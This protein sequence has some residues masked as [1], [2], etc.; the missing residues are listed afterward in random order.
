MRNVAKRSTAFRGLALAALLLSAA[1]AVAQEEDGSR[2]VI[3]LKSRTFT[4]SPGVEPALREGLEKAGRGTVGIVQL[5]EVPDEAVRAQLERAGVVLLDYIPNNA[6]IARIPVDL[7]RATAVPGVRFIGRLL[8]EDKLAPG[9]LRT[10]ADKAGKPELTLDVEAFEGTLE[11]AVGR[12]EALGGRVTERDAELSVLRIALPRGAVRDLAASDAV[13][14]VSPELP[15]TLH[16]NHSRNNSRA[17][18]VQAAPYG[19]T[20]AGVQLG[21]WD[22][23]QISA[24]PDFGTRLTVVEPGAIDNHATHVAGTMAGAGTASASAGFPALHFRGY[25]TGADILGFDFAGVPY[26]EHNVGINTW[27]IDNSQNSWGAN[28]STVLGNCALYGDYHGFSREY[29][30]IVTGIYGRRIPVV[31]SAGNERQDG[32]CGM[33]AVSPFLNYGIVPPPAT[34]KDVIAVGAINGDNGA[35]TT[36]SSWGPTDDGRLR[37]DLA[38]AGCNAGS[39]PAPAIVSTWPTGYAGICGTSMAAPA[40]SGTIGLLLQRYRAVCTNATTDPLPSTIKALLLHTARDMNDASAFLNPGP[41]FASGYGAMDTKDAVDMVPFHREDQ[42]S[43]GQTDTF[44]IT[45]TR[46]S[47][48]KVT[49]VWDDPAAAAGAGVALVNNLDL[50]LVEPNGVTIHRP[51]ILNPALP[52]ANA[53]TGVDNRNVVEQVVVGTVTGANAGVWT[54]RVRGTNVPSGPQ[55]YSLVSQHLKHADL[56]CHGNA[57]ADGWIMD[58]DAP[59]APVDPGT[60]PNPDPTA[61]WLSNQIWVRHAADGIMAHQNPELGSTPNYIYARVRNR[62]TTTLNTVRAMIYVATAST[63][64]GYPQGWTLVGESTVVNLAPGASTFITPVPW[65][66]PATGHYCLFVRLISDQDPMTFAE[67]INHDA[68]TR[69]NNNI[70]WRNVDVFD[71]VANAAGQAEVLIANTQ[72]GDAELA[73]N[74]DMLPDD[75]GITL[76]DLAVVDVKLSEKLRQYLEEQGIELG[77]D[78]GFERIDDLTFRM[79][80]PTAFLTP[81]PVSGQQEFGLTVAIERKGET[82]CSPIYTLDINQNFAPMSGAKSDLMPRYD[83]DDPNT[84]GVRYEVHVPH[85]K[86]LIYGRVTD[87]DGAPLPGV[88]LSVGGG[89]NATVTDAD[90]TYQLVVPTGSWSLDAGLEGLGGQTVKVEVAC[91]K[92]VQQ[93]VVL[94]KAEE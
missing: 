46:Q 37:P 49:L 27:G 40:V 30:R 59:L 51:W 39:A 43:H 77:H 25:S 72:H 44:Q 17:N 80:K 73:L 81:I 23:G 4:P 71:L 36:F 85:V 7:G 19:L 33:S 16:N 54:I 75:R 15:L 2:Y 88:T 92:K 63:G 28:V 47:N 86:G 26:T 78:D 8:V 89:E 62:G 24:H 56:S 34:A 38:A 14:W 11:E 69:N 9:L 70:A 29:D 20:G 91:G 76:F 74:F 53:T 10:L 50:E 83:P 52:T 61:M 21:I 6:W 31:F 1:A 90:G 18:L 65:F 35:M 64:L 48:L 45:V 79:V 55:R 93:D 58:K 82:A 67:G 42:V 5:E 66:P 87:A 13:R 68:N 32:D 94:R 84:G 41:D 3:H 57:G 22:G 12:V 60:E